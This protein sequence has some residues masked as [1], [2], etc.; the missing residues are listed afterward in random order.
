VFEIL[1]L[2][3]MQLLLLTNR[4]SSKEKKYAHY[5]AEASWAGARII[6]GQ[7]TPQAQELYNLLMSTFSSEQGKLCNME[8]LREHAGLSTDEWEDL[9][10]YTTQVRIGYL[11]QFSVAE[12]LSSFFLPGVKQ[13]R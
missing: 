10:Q 9:M 6:Q 3:Q 11:P 13:S 1:Q 5:L 12:L 4:L 8:V 7:Q 2:F